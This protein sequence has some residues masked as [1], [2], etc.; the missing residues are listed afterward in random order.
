M[1]DLCFE[2]TRNL[3][4]TELVLEEEAVSATLGLVA[5]W[6]ISSLQS[7]SDLSDLVEDMF[8]GGFVENMFP[9][10]FVEDMFPGDLVD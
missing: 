10:G 8:P 7:F 9:G 5:G 3:P 1:V 4:A 6:L 2:T